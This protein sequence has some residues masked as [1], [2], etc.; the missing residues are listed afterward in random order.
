M[1]DASDDS[2]PFASAE[3]Y[4]A[5][6]RPGYGDGAFAYLR[7]R[8][9]LDGDTRVLD[10]GCGAGQ[11]A[12]P[13]AADVGE[14]VGMDPNEAMLRA[15]RERAAAA[16]RENLRWRVGSDA[17]LDA[18]SG[19]FRLA[20]MGRSFHWTDQERTL[21]RLRELI[22]PG[23]GV[24]IL[25]DAEWLTRGERA[26]QDAV[27][28]AAAAHVSDLPERTGPVTEHE[29]PWDELLA[30]R[31]FVDVEIWTD[32]FEREWTAE[33]IVGYLLSLSFCSPATLGEDREA[34]ETAVRER[35][36]KRDRQRFAQNVRVQVIS[37][38]RPAD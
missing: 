25:T 27:Y 16:G 2:S 7:D 34:F 21:D 28:E 36:G 10:L 26:W 14:V 17:D 11:V 35:L 30:D 15:A 23:D 20:T 6:Y 9:A 13:L 4:Y 8:F 29:D 22:E 1:T 12:I 32:R 38:K 18:L 19:P 37:G 24:A 5:A 3:R 31:G 33:G